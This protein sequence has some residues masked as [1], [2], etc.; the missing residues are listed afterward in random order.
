MNFHFIFSL[1]FELV[2]SYTLID[3]ELGQSLSTSTTGTLKQTNIESWLS[4]ADPRFAQK[5]LCFTFFPSSL[6]KCLGRPGGPPAR[7]LT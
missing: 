2:H 5:F 4:L 6:L 7:V 3:I 1:S